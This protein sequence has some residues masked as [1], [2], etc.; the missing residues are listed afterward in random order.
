MTSKIYTYELR[1]GRTT[2][3]ITL[4]GLLGE[5]GEIVEFAGFPSFKG[6]KQKIY[7]L[8]ID[9]DADR[10]RCVSEKYQP[11]PENLQERFKLCN[12]FSNEDIY[13]E[14]LKRWK[15]ISQLPFQQRIRP[16]ATTIIIELMNETV[17]TDLHE[18]IKNNRYYLPPPVDSDF[19]TLLIELLFYDMNNHDL[20]DE[21]L[22]DHICD[23]INTTA[24]VFSTKQILRFK[25]EKYIEDIRRMDHVKTIAASLYDKIIKV[26]NQYYN[27]LED[28]HS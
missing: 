15:E 2:E 20:V 25:K 22:H 27:N 18:E 23:L 19:Y 16:F 12:Y 10:I 24:R 14:M 7:I 21:V 3:V 28:I 11:W 5:E 13:T 4:P 1:D 17:I 8:N 26:I 6:E 9:N